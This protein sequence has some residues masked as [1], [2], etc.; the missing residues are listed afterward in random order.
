MPFWVF[1]VFL[2]LLMSFQPQ[3]GQRAVAAGWQQYNCMEWSADGTHLIPATGC[4][5]NPAI[6]SRRQHMP[7]R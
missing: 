1:N 7:V 4:G 2:G 3:M 5:V 6:E